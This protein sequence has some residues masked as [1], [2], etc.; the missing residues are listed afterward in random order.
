MIKTEF[1]W[2]SDYALHARP[3]G[4]IVSTASKFASNVVI[5]TAS[6]S[7]N[8]KG[9][10]SLMGLGLK[11]GEKVNLV[12]DGTDE[13]EAEKAISKFLLDGLASK[14]QGSDG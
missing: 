13:V 3:A 2:I 9:L 12:V 11:K 5:E 8:A 7:A 14:V 6:S 1:I 10:F 4:I